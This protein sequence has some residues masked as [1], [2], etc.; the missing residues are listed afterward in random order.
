MP[1]STVIFLGPSLPL[2]EA[3][4]ILPDALYLP[5]VRRGSLAQFQQNPP[6]VIGIIDGSFFQT[7]SLSPMEIIPFLDQG[8]RIFGS[9]SMGAMRAVELRFEGMTG[10]GQIYERFAS[11]EFSADDDVAIT[12]HSETLRP[13]SE[14]LAN[15]HIALLQAEA[16][17]QISLRERRRITALLRGIYFPN[18]TLPALFLT[19]ARVLGAERASYFRTW[20]Q[21]YAPDAKAEDARALLRAIAKLSTSL[22]TN[23]EPLHAKAI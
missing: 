4:A 15:L 9:S 11:G 16:A 17:G 8:V 5:P 12:F 23:E 20:W 10:I 21:Q 7:L 14:P 19:A 3:R 6:A 1:D 22:Q 2:A 18:R 13:L